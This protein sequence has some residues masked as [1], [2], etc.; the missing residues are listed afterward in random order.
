M[1]LSLQ[2]PWNLVL[3]L[4]QAFP[5]SGSV[6]WKPEVSYHECLKQK[7]FGPV[8]TELWNRCGYSSAT[9]PSIPP[10]R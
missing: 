9:R 4:L 7:A 8:S 5:R 6:R 3:A 10:R 2:P 1:R